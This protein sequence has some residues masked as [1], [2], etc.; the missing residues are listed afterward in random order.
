MVRPDHTAAIL[1]ALIPGEAE[2]AHARRLVEAF[3]TARARGEERVL[4]DGL[5]VEVPAYLN[6][7]RL[8]REP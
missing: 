2:K 4:V 3:E 7:K 5:W 1:A 6:A 8:L